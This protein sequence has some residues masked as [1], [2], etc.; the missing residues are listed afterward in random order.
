[1]QAAE[2]TLLIEVLRDLAQGVRGWPSAMP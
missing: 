1:V 2:R